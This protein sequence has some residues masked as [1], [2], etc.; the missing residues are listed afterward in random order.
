MSGWK[1]IDRFDAAEPVW[2]GELA[3]RQPHA[4]AAGQWTA[5]ARGT[6]S[7]VRLPRDWRG[8]RSLQF[9]ITNPHP[10]PVIGGIEIWDRTEADG[11]ELAYGDWVDRKRALLL[12]E[13]KTHVV[14]RIDPMQTQ[15]GDRLLDLAHIVKV[16]LHFPLPGGSE[17]LEIAALRLSESPDTPDACARAVPGDS[18][19]CLKHQDIS[20]Y[21]YE[22]ERA[23]LPEDLR[24]LESEV[25]AERERLQRLVEAAEING[26]PTL[27]ARAGIVAADIALKSRPLLAWHFSAGARRRNLSGALAELQKHRLPLK[28][29]LSSRAHEDDED[30]SN[31]PL[32]NVRPLPDLK[33][34]RIEGK[35]FVD[36]A[37]APILICSMSYHNEGAL[38][39]FFSPEQHKMEIYAAGGGSRYDIE[40]S[41][42]YE[43]FHSFPDTERVGWKG[44]CG[45]LIKDQW[46]MGGRKEN[47]VICL[48]NER[49]LTA[50]DAYNREHAADWTNHPQL[51]YVIL[52]YELAY[53]C[54][55]EQSL[56]R[57]RVWLEE[58]HGAIERL[59]DCWG[60]TYASFE[61]ALPPPTVG[62]APAGDANR[63]AW[64]HWLFA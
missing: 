47:V 34:L 25:W 10:E 16:T 35:S 5:Q 23:E 8:Y 62:L 33:M 58:R 14:I 45:H 6:V 52:G 29:L 9:T 36:T 43:A 59:N 32:S 26:K 54:Y 31:L 15:R 30:D 1:F 3:K 22:P 27:Y 12:G 57:F 51:L 38:L 50:I 11:A 20:C 18:I 2:S 63:A 24:K 17:P 60:T 28:R 13:G 41:P 39:S 19:L 46:A 64:Y 21:T 55:C 44:W 42:V 56:Q 4:G 49:I 40:R 7:T 61:E 53:L 37:G 48:E